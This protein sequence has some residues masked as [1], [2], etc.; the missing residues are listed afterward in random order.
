MRILLLFLLGALLSV[1]GGSQT[2]ST[3]RGIG[4]GYHSPKDMEAMSAGISWWYNWFYM[5]DEKIR[6][7]YKQYGVEYIPMVWGGSF[8][9]TAI[10]NYLASNEDI[11]YLLG[12]NEPNFKDQA[13]LMPSHA[14]AKWPQLEEMAEAH[15]LQLIGPAV[16]YC[17]NCVSENGTT[18]NDPFEYLDDFFAACVGC[19]VD[20]ISVHWYGCGGLD[21][22]LAGFEKYGK[23]LWVTEIACWDNPNISL[24]Q[25]K[26]YLINVVDQMESNPM[27]FRYAWFTGRGSGPNIAL[28]GADGELTELG[29]IYVNMP[30]HNP[31]ENVAIPARIEAEHYQ[32]MSGIQLELTQD[33]D[34]FINVGYIDEGDWITYNLEVSEPGAYVFDIRYAGT[35][36]GKA[37]LYV[38]EQVVKTI[39]FPRTGGWQNWRTLEDSL[40]LETG[41]TQI[42]FKVLNGGFNLNWIDLLE[43][44]FLPLASSTDYRSEFKMYPN[45]ASDLVVLEIPVMGEHTISVLDL[46]G[47]VVYSRTDS[48]A[49]NKVELNLSG[50]PKGTYL[51]LVESGSKLLSRQ[52]LILR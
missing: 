22:Y 45:P 23:P 38:G 24:T 26:S 13:N 21:S 9:Q 50:L 41:S 42:T 32:T 11:G 25:Q 37:E 4:Y 33:E 18:Y 12:F 34:G 1:S 5:P 2:K 17:G 43:E 6:T 51:V 36:D 46:S 19:K 28:L 48:P 7:T 31:D 29:E 8:D 10:E 27:V 49:T 14:A 15:G 39:S 3:K 52:K 16:N 35:G 40:H 20:Y 47:K 44:R 30:T